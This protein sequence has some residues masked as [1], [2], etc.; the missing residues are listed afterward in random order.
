MS[1]TNLPLDLSKLS[2]MENAVAAPRPE[3]T[4]TPVEKEWIKL[5]D[6]FDWYYG[7]TD[8]PSVWKE[9]DNKRKAIYE[10]GKAMGLCE[11]RMQA[12]EGLIGP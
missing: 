10:K 5:W 2:P 6:G 7:Y 3:L 9:W 8:D 11:S 12:I 4:T 1:L